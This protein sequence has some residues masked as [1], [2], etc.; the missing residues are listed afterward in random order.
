MTHGSSR[1]RSGKPHRGGAAL[2]PFL[3][4]SARPAAG[5][6]GPH[7]VLAHRGARAVRAG[8][9]R[10]DHRERARRRPRSRSRLSQPYF[11]ALR[12]SRLDQEEALARRRAPKPD[13]DHGERPQGLRAAQQGLPRPGGRPARN[14]I[15]GGAAACRVRDGDGREPAAALRTKASDGAAAQP[16]PRRHGLGHLGAW[17]AVRAGIRMGHFVRGAGRQDRGRVSREVR[18]RARAL[19]DRR[20]RRGAGRLGVRGAQDRRGRQAASADRRSEGARTRIGEA[21]G[22]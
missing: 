20:T 12:R 11:S 4:A 17:R 5:K 19:L 16:P 10:A 9:S 18:S 3:H 6:P 21:A 13:R 1:R 2:Q 7:A 14:T 22:R 8:A 15:A